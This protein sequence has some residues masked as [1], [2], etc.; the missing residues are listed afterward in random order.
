MSFAL[1][2]VIMS[3]TIT[4][5]SGPLSYEWQA[6][7]QTDMVLRSDQLATVIVM[8]DF[9]RDWFDDTRNEATKET[10]AARR[11]EIIFAVCTLESYLLEWV[12][13]ILLSR[14]PPAEIL[15]RLDK[16]FP[17][18][19]R[20]S[21][22]RKWKAV[23]EAVYAD[24]L[25]KEKPDLSGQTWQT[26]KETVYEYYRNALVHASVSRPQKKVTAFLPP[27]AD[28]KVEL[29]KL[30]AGWAMEIVAELIRGLN[31]KAGTLT[32]D[33]VDDP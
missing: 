31:D 26:F 3:K 24:E 15:G 19:Q 16:Y 28:W 30:R 32:P 23:P 33:W 11:R 25:I 27:P 21:I 7:G 12:R 18:G 5:H 2:T 22:L 29:G 4:T 13:E 8:A 9:A 14:Y 20:N 6:A 1:G 10:A 17:K